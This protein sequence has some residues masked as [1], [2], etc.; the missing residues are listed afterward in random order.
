MSPQFQK[1]PWWCGIAAVQTALRVLQVRTTQQGIAS[2][3]HVNPVDGTSEEEMKRALL[4]YGTAVDEWETDEEHQAHAWLVEHLDCY[5]PAI[6]C[7]DEWEHWVTAIGRCGDMFVIF[8]SAKTEEN[9]AS[10]GIR[11]YSW[12]GLRTRWRLPRTTNGE[13]IFY[14]LGVSE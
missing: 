11:F 6:L 7:V 14:A 5:G 12:I 2:R 8:D 13:P 3:V 9:M 4:S 1:K 10:L